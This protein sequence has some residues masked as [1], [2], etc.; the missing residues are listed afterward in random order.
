MTGPRPDGVDPV[1]GPRPG[2][3]VLAAGPRAGGVH[4][5]L[6]VALVAAFVLMVVAGFAVIPLVLVLLV[7]VLM[8]R[9]PM[10]GRGG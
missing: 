2:G 10:K 4:P 6:L 1:A 8:S 9:W 5:L 7:L 3:V